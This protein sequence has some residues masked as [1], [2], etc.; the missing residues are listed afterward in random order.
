M[1]IFKMTWIQG[2]YYDHG[3]NFNPYIL[4][5]S[6]QIHDMQAKRKKEKIEFF[7]FLN[8]DVSIKLQ[9]ENKKVLSI[10]LKK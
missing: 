1:V 2:K 10:N 8:G 5:Y 7:F 4:W 9:S 3:P 6:R